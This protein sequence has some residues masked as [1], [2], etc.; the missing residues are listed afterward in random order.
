[1]DRVGLYTHFDQ[2]LH[3]NELARFKELIQRRLKREPLAYIIG[4]REFWSLSFKVTPDVL[5]PRPETELLVS[6]GLARLHGGERKETCRVLEIGT[7]SGAVAIALAKEVPSASFVA[8]DTSSAALSVAE[9]NA[10][11]HGVRDRIEFR[12]G[13]LFRPLND[14][15]RFDL[16]VTNPPYIPENQ[17]AS[18]DPEIRDHE[19]RMA[20]D[21]GA[22]GLDFYRRALPQTDLFLQPGGWFLAEIGA[23]E[24]EQVLRLA[25]QNAGLDSFAFQKDLAGIKRVFKARK[26]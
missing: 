15:E 26:K 3:P 25:R 24:D 9:D 8:T 11:T 2:P 17:I 23:G 18:L 6:E 1:M 5:I 4:R 13:D 7:G 21:G 12:R 22:D 10:R 14:G 20:L 16:V 19:P